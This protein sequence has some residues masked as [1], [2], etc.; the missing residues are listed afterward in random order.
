MILHIANDYS[1]S[2]VYKN[3]VGELDKLGLSQIIY[4]PIKDIKQIGI[5]EITFSNNDSRIIYSLILNRT[6]DRIFY[7]RKIN[8]I[9]SDIE[10]KIDI[11]KIK[12]IHAHTWY[13]DGG[14][15][16]LL[17]V[18]YNIPYIVAVRTTDL[19]IHYKFLFHERKFGKNVLS[20]SKKIINIGKYQIDFF[21]QRKNN[22]SNEIFSKMIIL[23]NGVDKFWLDKS[24]PFIPKNSFP[25]KILFV[26]TFIK[27][28]NLFQLLQAIVDIHNNNIFYCELHI[29]G[30][31]NAYSQ[32]LFDLINSYPNIFIYHGQIVCK[33]KLLKIYND[34]HVFAM[35]S[36]KETFGLVYVEALLQGLPLLYTS[37]EGIDG[38]YE[39][40][41]GEKVNSSNVEEIKH[42]LKI[43]YDNY[44]S[45]CIPTE[46]IKKNHDWKN[47]ALNYHKIYN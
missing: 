36:K 3:L 47:I 29:V 12:I 15:A 28:K 7:K 14:V 27:R 39:D 26:G 40:N 1:G 38:F 37:N 42:K 4:T 33:D 41:I 30:G 8:K 22:F 45:Y 20:S 13:S 44:Q 32:K 24:K 6:T 5:N 2:K 16:Y 46:I 34:C 11:S 18:K 23:P 25:F 9:V 19:N 21:Y 17:S 31:S 43:L 35:P 10:S